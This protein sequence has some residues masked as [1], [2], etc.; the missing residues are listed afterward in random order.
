MGVDGCLRHR[1]HGSETHVGSLEQLAPL[2]PCLALED[3]REALLQ[4]RPAARIE[5]RR[6]LFLQTE[7]LQQ[8]GIEL[9]FERTDGNVLA[10][11]RFVHV[12]E[13]RTGVEQ[14]GAAFVEEARLLY[15]VKDG[16]ECGGAVDHGGVNHLA[17]SRALAFEQRA[18]HA[19]RQHQPAAAE[20]PDEVER[21][22]RRLAA[23]ADVVEDTGQGDVVDVV[24]RRL[25]ERPFL[26]PTGHA[27]VDQTR[28][29]RQAD[30]GAESEAF[31]D[32][33]AVA[34]EQAVGALQQVENQRHPIG[35]L[36][37]D[38]DAAAAAAQDVQLGPGP[39]ARDGTRGALD[40]QD[41]GAHV[42]EQHAG[43]RAG[44]DPPDFD[45]SHSLQ[46]SHACVLS[47]P[48]G[49]APAPRCAP[50]LNARWR[51]RPPAGTAR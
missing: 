14:V 35:M 6:R 19:E 20:V 51:R 16:H 15:A 26:P 34:L 4:F 46:R 12:V 50:A 28:I 40:A 1:Q 5:L 7:A 2:L 21:R 8:L 37:V 30:V 25:G 10:V 23:T 33:G 27:A 49:L 36:Q 18:H 9:R 47:V 22:R 44:P 41:L 38:T 13:M 17:A 31:H 48:G 43:K 29:A 32:A 3:A 39:L 24:P 45:D 11:R 42:R